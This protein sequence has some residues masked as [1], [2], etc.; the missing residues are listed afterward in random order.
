MSR[1]VRTIM[2]QTA[3][4]GGLMGSDRPVGDRFPQRFPQIL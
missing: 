2:V 1:F 3:G 4:N